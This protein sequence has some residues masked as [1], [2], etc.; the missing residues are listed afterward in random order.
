MVRLGG[1]L[2]PEGT[3][4]GVGAAP[5]GLQEKGSRLLGRSHTKAAA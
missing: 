3:G 5:P 1:W 2:S 4:V